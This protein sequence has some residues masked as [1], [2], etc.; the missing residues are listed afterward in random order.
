MHY[1]SKI[2]DFEDAFNSHPNFPSLLAITDSLTFIG[3]ENIAAKVPFQ[4]IE[5]L[6]N[7]F[8]IELDTENRKLHILEKNTNSFIIIDENEKNRVITFSELEN[9]WTGIVLIIERNEHVEKFKGTNYKLSGFVL[10]ICCISILVNNW[11][12]QQS[13]FLLIAAIGILITI[14]IVKTYFEDNNSSESKFCSLNKEFSCNSIIKSKE[15]PFSKYIEFVDLPVIFFVFSFLGLLFSIISLYNIGLISLGSLPIISY[16]IYLQKTV[17]KKWCLLCL[18][19][20][21]LLVLNSVLF[22]FYFNTMFLKV[23]TI[24]NEITLLLVVVLA[25]FYIK[26]IILQNQA[27]KNKLNTLLRFKRN[28]DVFNGVSLDVWD[29]EKL[30]TLPK[31]IIGNSNAPN[32]IS[33]FLS[34]SCPHCDTAFKDALELQKK[35]PTT[36]IIEVAYNLN[37]KNT[38]NPYLDIAKV[39]MQLNNQ[40]ASCFE[41]LEDWHIKKLNLAEWKTKWMKNDDFILE[42]EQL[43]KQ[44]HWCVANEFNYAPVKLFNGKLIP[45]VYEIEELFYFFKEEE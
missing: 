41:A 29:A 31:I 9:I 21:S 44:F 37:S 1:A 7:I 43:E 20:S 40:N 2:N 15:Y 34:P 26:K 19:I 22:V 4:H 8:I 16:S 25:W 23:E 27:N 3:I 17:V 28:E 32:I 6:P 18:L 35:H 45:Q 38:E 30:R 33:L 12:I 10:I 5:Q 11:N 24:T 13:V 14:E 42:N 36:V 39:I